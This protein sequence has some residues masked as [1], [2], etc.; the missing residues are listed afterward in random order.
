MGRSIM[1]TRFAGAFSRRGIAPL[2][3]A[4]VTVGGV[5]MHTA[6]MDDDVVHPTHYPW[7]HS[8]VLDSFDMASVR[9]GHQVYQQVCASCHGLHRIAYRNLVDTIYT[10]DEVKLMLEVSVKY[11][12]AAIFAD[13]RADSVHDTMLLCPCA[14]SRLI[15]QF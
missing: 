13:L 11:A 14:A 8:G 7:S 2:G 6:S 5:A 4:G 15:R 3:A 12:C 9:R 10:E 1:W